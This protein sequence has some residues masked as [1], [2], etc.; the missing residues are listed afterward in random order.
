MLGRAGQ[1]SIVEIAMLAV[2][3]E[4]TERHEFPL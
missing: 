1:V 2:D 3:C 4:R